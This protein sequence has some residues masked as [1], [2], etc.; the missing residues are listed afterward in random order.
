MAANKI[1]RHGNTHAGFVFAIVAVVGIGGLIKPPFIRPIFVVASLITFPI[2][3]V[4]SQIALLVLFY[5]IVTPLGFF[6]RMRRRDLLQLHPKPDQASFWIS[7]DA[8]P[9]AE[10][11]LKQF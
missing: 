11:Y 6:W 2:G 4:V 7:R 9:S 10:R 3:W 5:G 1:W 8:E